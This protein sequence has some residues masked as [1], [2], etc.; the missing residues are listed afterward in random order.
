MKPL[1]ISVGIVA[2]NEEK[3]I[4]ELLG[5][6]LEQDYQKSNTELLLINSMSTDSTK[7]IFIKFKEENE[8]AY[9]SIKII[10]NKGKIQASGWNEAIRNFSGEALIRLDAHARIEKDFI[11]KNAET[12]ESG[13]LVCG[14]RR[15]NLP[16]GSSA[17]NLLV[18]IADTSMFGGSFAKY[19]SSKEKTYVD[20]VFHGCYRREVLEKV[21]FFNEDLGRTEDN[22][23]HQRI[24]EE[25]YKICYNPEIL[26]YQFSRGRIVDSVR[27]KYGNGYWIGRT[28]AINPRCIYLFHYVP[29]L[30]LVG[31]ILASLF[32]I[33][34]P[35]LLILTVGAY[36]LVNLLLSVM[37][38]ITA[39]KKHIIYIML[40][41][42]FWALHLSYGFGTF[43]GLLS[44]I[45]KR[46]KK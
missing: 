46:V 22:D 24:R 10:D 2:F 38:I 19:H 27:Q 32:S 25:G 8:S 44:I 21:G 7:D 41:L 9:K 29:F 30:F 35:I 33:I 5:L 28:T 12:L 15:P 6:L 26:S 13:E 20:T 34:S 3:C 17:Q 36:S 1:V 39:E 45:T 42:M 23:F 43:M 16:L 37:A 40:P 4:G 18:H 14:G 11:R 31:L